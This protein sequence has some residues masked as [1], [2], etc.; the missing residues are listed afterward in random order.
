MLWSNRVQTTPAAL[1][2]SNVSRD[3][4]LRALVEMV[5][6]V[7]V[8]FALS[9]RLAPVCSIV[10]VATAVAATIYRCGGP[11]QSWWDCVLRC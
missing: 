10:I 6:A 4:G 11:R 3:R 1:R 9:W 7:V 8:L 5:G 2:C